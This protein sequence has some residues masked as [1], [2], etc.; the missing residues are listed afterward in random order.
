MWWW[1][2]VT[3]TTLKLSL[4]RPVISVISFM[5]YRRIYCNH[6]PLFKFLRFVVSV[7]CLLSTQGFILWT[8]VSAQQ[9]SRVISSL[10]SC[11]RS[12]SSHDGSGSSSATAPSVCQTCWTGDTSAG[13]GDPSYLSTPCKSLGTL[14]F[15][16]FKYKIW[17]C[18][19]VSVYKHFIVL[20]M[21]YSLCSFVVCKCAVL[22]IKVTAKITKW[23]HYNLQHTVIR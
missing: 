13:W 8:G 9:T 6:F 23:K 12:A 22:C 18:V 19:T 2:E 17:F 5:Y 16:F 10:S 7:P 3:P 1:S 21:I 14:Y 15:F 20:I 4:F 11:L